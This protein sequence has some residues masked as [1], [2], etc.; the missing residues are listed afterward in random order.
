MSYPLFI[1]MV[2][3]ETWTV[4]GILGGALTV[5]LALLAAQHGK[6]DTKIDGLGARLDGIHTRIDGV[7]RD[8]GGEVKDLRTEV[9]G[10]RTEV[11]GIRTD[12]R[13]LGQ[14][15]DQRFSEHEAAHP[16]GR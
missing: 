10:L 12:V 3:I 9:G 1:L 13:A 4:I 11:G 6:L 7:A 15:M 2:V 14:R 8:L 16:P 5:L